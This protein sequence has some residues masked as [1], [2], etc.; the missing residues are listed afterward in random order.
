MNHEAF[1]RGVKKYKHDEKALSNFV[2]AYRKAAV[3]LYQKQRARELNLPEWLPA[4]Y[5][6]E[7]H[8]R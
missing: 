6:G 5:L 2:S 8:S 1:L 3:E 7:R 4:L